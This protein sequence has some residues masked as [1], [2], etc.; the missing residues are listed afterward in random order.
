MSPRRNLRRSVG[1]LLLTAAGALV[2]ADGGRELIAVDC[3][4]DAGQVYD[5]R[6]QPCRND[7]THRPHLPYPARRPVL[8]S[9]AAALTLL[10]LGLIAS[11]PSRTRNKGRRLS[12]RAIDRDQ[13]ADGV[14]TVAR[15]VH[16]GFRRDP[17]A[18]AAHRSSPSPPAAGNAV[19]G[20]PDG[21]A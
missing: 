6:E 19:P 7:V 21:Y 10:S 1:L 11:G 12:L 13:R 14:T 15:L 8:L 9:G 2:L 5:Y 20:H 16:R 3:C 4:L 18:E 17:A